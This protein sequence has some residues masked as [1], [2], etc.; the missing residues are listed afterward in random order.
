MPTLYY[1][2]EAPGV[3]I[4]K[5]VTDQ[6]VFG[7]LD[8]LDLVHSFENSVYT[9][10][11]FM[12][13]SQ[14]DNT[15]GVPTLT[16][17]RC[18]VEVSYVMDKSQVP[19]PVDTPYTTTAYGIRSASK[20]NH[21]PLF[22][23]DKAGILIEHHTV[24]CAL[25][26]RF[27]LT[28]VTFD[29]VSK[30]F[31]TIQSKYKGSL[32]QTPFHLSFS[33]P[34][35]VGMLK[36][37]IAAYEAKTDYQSKTLLDYINDMKKTQISFDVRK[38]QLTDPNA[39]KELLIRC[40]ELNCLAQLTMD[41]K[42]PDVNLI[43][44]LPDT[45]S[46]SFTMVLQFGRPTLVAIHTPISIDNTVLP[47]GLF[48][49]IV[50]NFHYSPDVGG[51]YQ[52]LMCN[53]FMRRSYG[54]YSVAQQIIRLP[55]YDD[56][57][58]VDDQYRYFEYRPFLIA[59]FTLDGPSTTINLRQLDD[60]KLH[61]IVQSIMLETGNRIFN[62]GGLFTVGVY[63]G[64]LRLGPE[65]LSLDDDL[66]LTILSNR[67]DKVYHLVLSET[68]NIRKM[69]VDWDPIL[70]KYRY[71]FPLTIERNLQSLVKKK[72]FNIAY[73]DRFL[74][75]ISKLER[76]GQL[77][78]L[79]STMISLGE[80]TNQIYSYTQNPSQLADY[81]VYTQSARTDYTLPT[82]TDSVSQLVNQYYET[83]ASVESRSLFVAFIEQCLISGILTLDT[84]IDQY[85]QPNQ[86]VYPYYSG[87]G[88]YYGF[89][90]PLRVINYT[91]NPK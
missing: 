81:L 34:V 77:K 55:V 21:T 79:L 61:P 18:D 80:D 62:Y 63:A 50:T 39:D 44:N 26:M 32:I 37:L 91:I 16:K 40:Q 76:S 5:A 19:W 7:L 15:H 4:L 65:L 1:R 82:G 49:N 2:V 42:E 87:Q 25:E 84:I 38:S 67:N 58:V 86:T 45:Y 83:K 70:I 59:H 30:A 52:D 12:A 22:I 3:N 54:N 43:D 20:G 28:F 41:Q 24:A 29:E 78:T 75:L 47:Y 14:Y 27:I 13:S 57:F 51:T 56:W 35:S 88:A 36:F 64:N 72:Y 73:E 89:N 71:F 6:A 74:S 48:E 85:I 23:D 10:S 8:E 60:V 90:T 46:I 68:T 11:S 69:E 33:Y 53:E 9:M 31:D 66:N 17:N